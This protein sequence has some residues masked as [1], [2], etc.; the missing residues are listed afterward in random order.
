[1]DDRYEHTELRRSR[2]LRGLNP[3]PF[4]PQKDCPPYPRRSYKEV[5]DAIGEEGRSNHRC[6]LIT[7]A[8]NMCFVIAFA[9][10]TYKQPTQ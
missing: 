5:I 9:Y 7:V 2:R 4:P 1:M 6:E 10:L 3:G 8:L